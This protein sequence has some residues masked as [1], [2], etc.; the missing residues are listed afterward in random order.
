MSTS[1]LITEIEAHLSS[2]IC[3]V[4]RHSHDSYTV[5]SS[6][7]VVLEYKTKFFCKDITFSNSTFVLAC[8]SYFNDH[9]LFSCPIQWY[10]VYIIRFNTRE[11]VL[12]ELN[13]SNNDDSERLDNNVIVL[14]V[15]NCVDSINTIFQYIF[16]S[17][18]Y[19]IDT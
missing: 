7:T 2:D 4:W 18:G 10:L 9:D 19:F 16:K 8:D 11:K 17:L 13:K 5:M 15:H 3:S 12:C 14:Y 1:L 6:H